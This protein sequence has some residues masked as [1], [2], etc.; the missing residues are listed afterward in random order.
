MVAG[1][2][3]LQARNFPFGIKVDHPVDV[4]TNASFFQFQVSSVKTTVEVV[5]PLVMALY[6]PSCAMITVSISQY[7][8]PGNNKIS[9]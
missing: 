4:V 5:D 1:P 9:K 7:C 3:S 6:L 2:P 8:S